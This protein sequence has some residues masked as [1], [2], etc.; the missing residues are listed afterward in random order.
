M[1]FGS[2]VGSDYYYDTYAPPPEV[3]GNVLS[4][5]GLNFLLCCH[6]GLSTGFYRQNIGDLLWH[7]D[8]EHRFFATMFILYATIGVVAL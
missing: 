4:A 3:A 7:P 1:F 2:F 6:L 5:S 8:P